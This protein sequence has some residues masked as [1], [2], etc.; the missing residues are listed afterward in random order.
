MNI[1]NI[2]K[3]FPKG[4][5]LY[6]TIW[7]YVTFIKVSTSGNIEVK[8][9]ANNEYYT[10]YS[11]G[12][13]CYHGECVLFPSKEQ[14]DWNNI[15]TSF[16]YGDIVAMY[17]E[18]YNWTHIAIFDK[19]LNDGYSKVICTNVADSNIIKIF[20]KDELWST[21]NIRKATIQETDF[22]F[23]LL[24]NQGY[25]WDGKNLL[26]KFCIKSLKPYDKVLVRSDEGCWYPSLISYID[27]SNNIYT[28][29][30]DS[31]IRYVIPFESNEY[32]IGSFD[33]PDPYYITWE[34]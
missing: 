6:T 31:S 5:E 12:K 24:K 18:T 1:A 25:T 21:K 15:S 22:F 14:H 16:K 29:D 26:S 23:D 13:Y 9:C 2:L 10:L 11:D 8:D 17:N 33:D 34:E 20:E 28:I 4:T 3:N 27:S 7:G 19:Q 32:L 30:Q